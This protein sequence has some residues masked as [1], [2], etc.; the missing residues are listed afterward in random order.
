MS[1]VLCLYRTES[2]IDIIGDA[3]KVL[4][5]HSNSEVKVTIYNYHAHKDQEGIVVSVGNLPYDC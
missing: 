1:M 2:A 3:Q 4:I 5:V